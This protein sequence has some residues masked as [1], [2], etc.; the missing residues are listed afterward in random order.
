MNRFEM[1]YLTKNYGDDQPAA[2]AMC[3]KTKDR[4]GQ[5]YTFVNL[6]AA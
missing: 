3:V 4:F 5:N 2:A 1:A 6:I